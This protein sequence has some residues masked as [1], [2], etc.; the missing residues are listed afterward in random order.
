MSNRFKSRYDDDINLFE[1]RWHLAQYALLVALLLASA[2]VTTLD[3]ATGEDSPLDPVRGVLADTMGPAQSA[4]TAVVRPFTAIGGWFESNG[5]L[6]DEVAAGRAR[7][8]LSREDLDAEHAKGRD[9][10]S[11][12]QGG[13]PGRPAA[14]ATVVQIA[15]GPLPPPHKNI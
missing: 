6:R 13:H 11:T 5:S 7:E 12:G 2:T 4:A 1:G 14:I 15:T 3:L 10:G 9:A 8:R